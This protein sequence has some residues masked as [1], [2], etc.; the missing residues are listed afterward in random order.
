MSEILKPA[1]QSQS[2]TLNNTSQKNHHDQVQMQN[3][4]RDSRRNHHQSVNGLI[5]LFLKKKKGSLQDPRSP[6]MTKNNQG[7]CIHLFSAYLGLGH[8]GSSLSKDI[9][10]SFSPATSSRLSKGT[11]KHSQGQPRDIIF[12]MYPES[13]PRPPSDGNTSPRRLLLGGLQWISLLHYLA[14]N[15]YMKYI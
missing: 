9:Q 15:I 6:I 3:L 11:Q 4:H 13:A 2:K 7:R 1:D 14:H 5:F 12:P 8:E 10:T